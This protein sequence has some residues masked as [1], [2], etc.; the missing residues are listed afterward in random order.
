MILFKSVYCGFAF[1]AIGLLC[2]TSGDG[3]AAVAVVISL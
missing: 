2:F 1:N 3:G